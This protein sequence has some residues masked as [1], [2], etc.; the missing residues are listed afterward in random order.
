MTDEELQKLIQEISE[1][2]SHLPDDREKPLS[3]EERKRKVLLQAKSKALNSIKTAREKDNLNQETRAS[4]DYTLLCEYGEK[5]PLL[6][7]Y[8]KSQLTWWGL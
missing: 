6:M 1:Q 4:I 3:R 7:N 5:H 8:V 2:I